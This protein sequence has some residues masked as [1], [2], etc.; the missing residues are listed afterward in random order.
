ML[1]FLLLLFLNSSQSLSR[2]LLNL[3]SL[4][5]SQCRSP[6]PSLLSSSQNPSSRHKKRWLL[7][8]SP[9][10]SSQSPLPS[11]FSKF[12]HRNLF[13]NSSPSLHPSL[14]QKLLLSLHL[15]LN[16]HQK[17]LL[18]PS[19]LLSLSLRPLPSLWVHPQSRS[20]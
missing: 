6:S 18:N 11:L 16:P 13:L 19:P 8:R 12:L 5:R 4:N 14:H 3:L 20:Q 1:L 7:L 17:L 2:S 10:R 9:W 15:S